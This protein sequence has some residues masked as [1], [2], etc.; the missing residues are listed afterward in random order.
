MATVTA[1]HWSGRAKFV[2]LVTMLFV[3]L[4]TQFDAYAAEPPHLSPTRGKLLVAT[5]QIRD[6]FFYHA[7]VLII[8]H[9]DEGTLGLIV[10]KPLR[11]RLSTSLGTHPGMSQRLQFGGPVLPHGLIGLAQTEETQS[12]GEEIL[13][14][15]YL[16]AGP[17]QV[18]NAADTLPSSAHM[19][20]YAGHAGWGRSQLQAEIQRGDWLVAPGDAGTLLD[21]DSDELWQQLFKKWNGL[22]I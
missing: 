4:R 15:T 12:V 18:R 9:G 3:L 21:N 19:K 10:N 6:P 17:S 7:V 16:L 20:V 2:A 14:H 13:P 22:W 11:V 8:E 1:I 5:E